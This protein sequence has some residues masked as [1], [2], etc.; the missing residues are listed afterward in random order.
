MQGLTNKSITLNTPSEKHIEQYVRNSS[1]LSRETILWIEE[2][3]EKDDEIRLLTE[4]YREFY[5]EIASIRNQKTRPDSIPSIIHLTP[6]EN[7]SKYSKGFVL[8][9]QTPVSKKKRAGLKTLKTFV[10][11]EHKTLIRILHD[12]DERQSKLF[13]I[14]ELVAEDDI[15]MMNVADQQSYFVSEP[16]GM[17]T[18]SDLQ[19]SSEKITDWTHCKLYLPVAKIYVYKDGETGNINIDSSGLDKEHQQISLEQTE[20]ELTITTE[21]DDLLPKKMVVHNNNHSLFRIADEGRFTISLSDLREP[22]SVLFFY[23]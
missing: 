2:W 8:A 14:S 19:I 21:F 6:F 11:K 3:I 7:Q 13:V 4:W 20:N 23:N 16:G 5:R 12:D 22:K 17:F 1:E 10:S 18:I 9:A 15:V